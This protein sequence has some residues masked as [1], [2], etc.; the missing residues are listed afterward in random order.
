MLLGRK[1]CLS[2]IIAELLVHQLLR[3]CG[4]LAMSGPGMATSSNSSPWDLH[5]GRLPDKSYQTDKGKA[6]QEH[7]KLNAGTEANYRKLCNQVGL[8]MAGCGT[9]TYNSVAHGNGA[10]IAMPP[11]WGCNA[12]SFLFCSTIYSHATGADAQAYNAV[13]LTT[14]PG[15]TVDGLEGTYSNGPFGPSRA[16][17]RDGPKYNFV[18]ACKCGVGDCVNMC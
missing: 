9:D 5:W 16:L 8:K 6:Q 15:S 4:T 12:Q 13:A 10:A 18:C 7:H 1:A 17:G 11:S 2:Q 3:A 14:Y